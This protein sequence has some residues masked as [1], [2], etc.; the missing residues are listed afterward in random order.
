[1]INWRL[2]GDTTVMCAELMARRPWMMWYADERSTP[3][4]RA[5]PE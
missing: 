4:L 2:H 3:K 5:V 1:L